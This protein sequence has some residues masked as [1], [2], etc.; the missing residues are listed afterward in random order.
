[1]I[2]KRF[3]INCSLRTILLTATLG[4]S[5]FLF[6]QT[7]FFLAGAICGMVAVG[8][9]IALLRYVTRT[10]RN[11]SQLLASI[12]YSDLSQTF[13]QSPK[14][15][16]FDDLARSL[17]DVI[18]KFRRMNLEKEE[19]FRFLQTI[20]DH[21]GI[22]LLAYQAD[23]AVEL[24][25]NAAKR[26]LNVPVLRNIDELS[27]IDPKLLEALHRISPGENRL[28]KL[29]RDGDLLQLSIYATGFVSNRRQLQLVA[30]QNI[31]SE[32]EEKEMMAWQNLI[33]V[34]THEIMNSIA[35]IASLASTANA[36]LAN[37]CMVGPGDHRSERIKDV[38]DAVETIEK[39]SKGLIAFIEKY[40]ELTRI[41]QPQF[42][43]V[44]VAD[45]VERVK[46][47]MAEQMDR[48]FIQFKTRVDP[49]TLEITADPALIEQVL[50]NL[51]KNA[52]EAMSAAEQPLIEL[53]AGTDGQGNPIIK[54]T[55]N[56]R[57]IPDEVAERIFIPFFTTK[58]GGSGIGLSLSRQIMRLHKGSLNVDSQ[59]GLKT[60]FALR[61]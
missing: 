24:H 1:M 4:L 10:N 12:E 30:M 31:Q 47:L 15:C 48:R 37:D 40:R 7:R 36:L 5:A 6:L 20:V 53:T 46:N 34:L 39:R 54:V 17:N 28:V 16:G 33:R 60:V 42:Q 43:I 27:G 21:V 41:P 49:K 25:N 3:V 29:Q 52:M 18:N 55:D 50:I 51:C 23:G 45:L 57:G 2:L 22:G 14:G 59:P 32:L 44:E 11:V 19:Q 38:C 8:Q 9:F 56:G 61:F 35:P 26:L 58:Q 13:P